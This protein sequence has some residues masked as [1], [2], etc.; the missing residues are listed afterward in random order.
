MKTKLPRAEALRIAELFCAVLRPHCQIVEYA[1]SLRRGKPEVSDIEICY[2]PRY[3][4]RPKDLF[5][6]ETEAV[7][8]VELFIEAM[9]DH[10][11]ITKRPNAAGVLTWGQLNK[12]AVHRESGIPVDFFCEPKPEHWPRTITIRTGPKEFNLRLIMS[13]RRRGIS[14]HAYGDPMTGAGNNGIIPPVRTEQ[15]FIEAC[16]LRYVHPYKRQ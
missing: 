15:D 9:V 12:L 11:I 2:V 10:T 8:I 16:G 1:G 7:S 5:G 13:A 14:V 4:S 6:E 3:A